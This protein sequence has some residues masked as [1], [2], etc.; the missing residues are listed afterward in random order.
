[1]EKID[2]KKF[3]EMMDKMSAKEKEEFVKR[4][5]QRYIDEFTNN[6]HHWISIHDMI[7]AVM[8]NEKLD[9][10]TWNDEVKDI[11]YK[12]KKSKVK[13]LTMDDAIGKYK[14]K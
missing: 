5:E 14:I 2:P 1:M 7:D 13:V 11:Y 8:K 6:L 10:I 12:I 3:T 9:F 4:I